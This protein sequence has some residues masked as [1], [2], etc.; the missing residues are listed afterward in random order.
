MSPG[1]RILLGV[2]CVLV[3]GGF[4]AASSMLPEPRSFYG[5]I[6]CGIFSLLIALACFSRGVRPFAV[7]IIAFVVVEL[8]IAYIWSQRNAPLFRGSHS[9]PALGPAIAFSLVFGLPAVY[10]LFTGR[11]P[12]W[13][14]WSRGFMHEE[15]AAKDIDDDA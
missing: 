12:R 14:K 8:A 5:L 4:F 1:A 11:L 3:A 10:V 2:L 6:A 9:E 7:R 13:S 15:R